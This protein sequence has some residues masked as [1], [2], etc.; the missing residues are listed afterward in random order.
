MFQKPWLRIQIQGYPSMPMKWAQDET[1]MKHFADDETMKPLCTHIGRGPERFNHCSDIIKGPISCP[2]SSTSRLG[3]KS[4]SLFTCVF[5]VFPWFLDPGQP[6]EVQGGGPLLFFC[7]A[8][9]FVSTMVGFN[10]CRPGVEGNLY[11]DFL[12]ASVPRGP[13]GE[14]PYWFLSARLFFSGS[15]WF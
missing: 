6:R 4:G 13:K 12:L 2:I 1:T 10:M 14:V 9:C 5:C 11:I 7:Q 15:A 3:D 8:G